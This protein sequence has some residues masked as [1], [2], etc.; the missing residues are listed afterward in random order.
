MIQYTE[1]DLRK[2]WL[3]FL[4]ELYD[5][6]KEGYDFGDWPDMEMFREMFEQE[7]E[8]YYSTYH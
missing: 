7:L 3:K 4:F 2:A 5:L 8:T 1:E 6:E